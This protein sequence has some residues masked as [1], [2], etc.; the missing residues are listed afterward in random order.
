MKIKAIIG[1]VGF[2]LK[3]FAPEILLGVGITG[4]VGSTVMACAA[5]LKA[6]EILDYY[7]AKKERIDDCVLVRET[8]EV[9]YTL[10]EEKADRRNLAGATAGKFIRLYGPSV[11]LMGVSIGCILASFKI[12]KTRNAALMAAY[13]LLEESFSRYRKRVVAKYGEEADAHFF[14]GDEDTDND[15]AV[16]QDED[17]AQHTK[18]LNGSLSGF[19]REFSEEVPDQHGGHYGSTQWSKRHDYNLDF[20]KAKTDHFNRMLLTK[21][22]V[23]MNDVYDELGFDPTEAGMICGWRYK[24]DR[25]DGFISFMP[26]GIDGNWNFGHDGDPII[27]D[28]NID[29]VIFDQSVARKEMK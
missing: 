10:S 22:F 21:G 3:K 20:L 17:G 5:T 26:R 7:E 6:E 2:T 19:A 25:G 11:T 28:F 29:G 13:K 15:V 9:E 12:M 4:A 23:T 14:Y 1:T 18:I 8:S 16:V 27:L 24:S